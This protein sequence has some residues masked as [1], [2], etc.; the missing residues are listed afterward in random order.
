MD[1]KNKYLFIHSCH[2]K[3]RSYCPVCYFDMC[4]Q[5]AALLRRFVSFNK[6]IYYTLFSFSSVSKLICNFCSMSLR[7]LFFV[8]ASFILTVS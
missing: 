2:L 7:I 3:F 4:R 1:D 5:L 6:L 8:L